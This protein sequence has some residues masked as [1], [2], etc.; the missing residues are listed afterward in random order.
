LDGAYRHLEVVSV[1]ATDLR[2]EQTRRP[3]GRVR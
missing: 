3:N 2:E 1:A